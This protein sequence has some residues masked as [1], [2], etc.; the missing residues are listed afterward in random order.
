M[1]KLKQYYH[2]I[3]DDTPFAFIHYVGASFF[4][5]ESDRAAFYLA[6]TSLFAVVP[7][8]TV[9]Y[10]ILALIPELK[11][12]ET[13][14]Q[15]F[16]FEHFVPATGSELQDYLHNFSQQ[17]SNLTS[18]G[19]V[20]LFVTSVLMLRKIE[21]SFNTI[22]H[23]SES[24]KGINGFLLYWALLSLGP[25][26]MGGAFAV[27]SY[28]A[29][30]NI[31]Y[32]IVPLAGTKR[33]VFSLLPIFMSGIAFALAYIAIP[34]TRVP[35]LH[36]IA[37]GLVAAVLFDLARRAVTLFVS[38]FPTYQLVYGAFAA[39]PIFLIWILVSWNILL[40]GAEIV[41][42]MTSF[43]GQRLHATS[44]LGNIL[45]ILESLYRMQA[46]GHVTEEVVFQQK[47]PWITS[48]EW[49]NYTDILVDIQ[50]VRRSGEGDITLIRD[51]HKYTLAQLFMDCFGDTMAL[52]LH[53]KSGWHKRVSQ[54]HERGVGECLERWQ[55]NLADL[56][57][58][59]ADN[60][61]SE[62][63]QSGSHPSPVIEE[64]GGKSE[65]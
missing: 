65:V 53:K 11:G 40:I 50:L 13:S 60:G 44:S 54:L 33:F 17:A 30:L 9:V 10:S 36:G 31:I 51:L 25:V 48:R 22:W 52:D 2:R 21:T 7:I 4:R 55:I 34:N 59:S 29:S 19:V 35:F 24:R 39:V 15:D 16:V 43:K 26:L 6:F 56:F 38:M 23:V 14:M 58:T 49:E 37:G 18:V 41:Q 63:A 28:V 46:S 62:H 12:M 64:K 45:S 5:H 1:D 27:S 32:D 47:M 57:D 20:M 42:A 3:I 61:T 8:M